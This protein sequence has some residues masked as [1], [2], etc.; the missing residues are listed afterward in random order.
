LASFSASRFWSS[1]FA[2]AMSLLLVQLTLPW[3]NEIAD[4]DISASCGVIRCSGRLGIGFS[5]ITGLVAGSYPAFYLSG[6]SAGESFER[7][8]PGGSL[9]VDAA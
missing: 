4:K 5:L 7:H 1:F 8:F 9:C 6:F 3:F 2:F